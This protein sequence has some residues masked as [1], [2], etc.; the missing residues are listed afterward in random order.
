MA[1]RILGCMNLAM[2]SDQAPEALRLAW[3]AAEQLLLQ[4]HDNSLKWQNLLQQLFGRSDAIDLSGITVEIITERTM[5]GMHAAYAPRGT[6]SNEHIYI[7][8]DWLK[9]RVLGD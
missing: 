7:N 4:W 1:S 9:K 8:G 6:D 5:P 3:H 2:E